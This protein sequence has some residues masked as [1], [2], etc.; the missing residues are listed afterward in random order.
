MAGKPA[1]MPPA[2]L[3]SAISQHAHIMNAP[4]IPPF[5]P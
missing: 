4:V 5:P 2:P 1:M 3:L